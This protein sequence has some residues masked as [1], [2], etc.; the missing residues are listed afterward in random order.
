M[1]F[2]SASRILCYSRVTIHILVS[3][4]GISGVVWLAAILFPSCPLPLQEPISYV[5]SKLNGWLRLWRN[6]KLN[7]VSCS[8]CIDYL[9]SVGILKLKIF[10]LAACEKSHILPLILN[11]GEHQ[12]VVKLLSKWSPIY[13]PIKN[14]QCNHMWK[15]RLMAPY[16]P[17]ITI[18]M[19]LRVKMMTMTIAAMIIVNHRWVP[20]ISLTPC[21]HS[22]REVIVLSQFSEEEMRCRDANYLTQAQLTV[23]VSCEVNLG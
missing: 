6:L 7:N 12:L 1:L 18:V 21:R 17:S 15:W 4:H 19:M 23:L 2:H 13:T 22:V 10:N 8:R 9:A 14:I 3:V 11:P 16:H 5:S 20:V